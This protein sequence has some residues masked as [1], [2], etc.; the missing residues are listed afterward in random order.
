MVSG[1]SANRCVRLDK[2]REIRAGV[3]DEPLSDHFR[4]SVSCPPDTRVHIRG[5]N[6]WEGTIWIGVGNGYYI[7]DYTTDFAEPDN[8]DGY[9]G[10]FGTA[11]YFMGVLFGRAFYGEDNFVIW[12]G[13][14]FATAAEAE[15]DIQNV[16]LR[17][18]PWYGYDYNGG[19][20]LCG[21][22]LK[23]DGRTGLDGAVLPIDAVNRGRSY[24]WRDLRPRHYV[25]NVTPE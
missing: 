6:V 22:V 24:Y 10:N 7:A 19:L 4:V 21:I 3:V 20:P 5:G 9:T 15:Q 16:A 8:I 17:D 13:N 11:D 2:Q 23:N 14:E 25:H 1:Y 12:S 18:S